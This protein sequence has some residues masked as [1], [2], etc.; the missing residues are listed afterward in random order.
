M[1]ESIRELEKLRTTIQNQIRGVE[2]EI[3]KLEERLER[4][5]EALGQLRDREAGVTI[6]LDKLRDV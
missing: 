1:T 3:E 5:R 6:S 2:S 4:Q